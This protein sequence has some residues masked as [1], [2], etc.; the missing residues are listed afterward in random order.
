MFWKKDGR[1]SCTVLTLHTTAKIRFCKT[2]QVLEDHSQKYISFCYVCYQLTE[3]SWNPHDWAI[4]I[5]SGNGFVPSGTKLSPDVFNGLQLP[6][7]VNG[8][9]FHSTIYLRFYFYLPTKMSVH[10]LSPVVA[11]LYADISVH[12]NYMILSLQYS[13]VQ[14]VHFNHHSSG[15]A[16]YFWLILWSLYISIPNFIQYGLFHQSS[17]HLY[18]GYYWWGVGVSIFGVISHTADASGLSMSCW[19][20]R[21]GILYWPDWLLDLSFKQCCFPLT[22]AVCPLSEKGS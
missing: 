1:I 14:C 17:Y 16:R 5:E 4:K 7:G 20:S 6:D 3:P 9:R 12:C 2:L 13:C 11:K 18:L 19:V 21:R 15:P 8:L 22:D 10:V